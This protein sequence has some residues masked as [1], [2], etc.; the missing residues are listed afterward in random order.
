L[1][2]TETGDVV[3]VAAETLR[4]RSNLVRGLLCRDILYFIRAKVVVDNV[5]YQFVRIHGRG[6]KFRL[7]G[8]ESRAI[9]PYFIVPCKNL[10]EALAFGA[11]NFPWLIFGKIWG[12]LQGTV[13]Y[14][15]QRI[16]CR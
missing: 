13:C 11:Q 12:V 8:E 14:C 7:I 9:E 3:L 10:S 16:S 1:S 6:G 15:R 4:F 5:P 2:G